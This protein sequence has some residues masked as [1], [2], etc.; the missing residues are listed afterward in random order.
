MIRP[1]DDIPEEVLALIPDF[2]NNVRQDVEALKGAAAR[3]DYVTLAMIAHR[4]KGDGASFFLDELSELGKRLG[5]A[6]KAKDAEGIR[7]SI[8]AV[9]ECVKEE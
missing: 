7:A 5:I 4:L 9:S 8:M 1:K 3:D 2:L 6:V